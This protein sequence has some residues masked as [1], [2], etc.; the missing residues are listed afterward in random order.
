MLSGRQEKFSKVT[1]DE[2]STTDS[3]GGS[4][5]TWKK[6]CEEHAEE[7]LIK[8]VQAKTVES[9]RNPDMPEVFGIPWPNEVLVCEA[10]FEVRQDRRHHSDE[11]RQE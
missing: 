11:V 1:T 9:E 7:D 6:A 4:W 2:T 5:C 8:M 3:K 10:L